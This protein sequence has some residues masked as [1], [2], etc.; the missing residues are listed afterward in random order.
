MK[1]KYLLI[2]LAN[3]FMRS[4]HAAVKAYDIEEKI[5]FGIHSTLQSIS[6]TFRD[7][8]A[9]HV[10]VM[11]E[12]HSWRRSFYSR[13]K[14]NRDIARDA[15]TDKEA[16]ES[17]LAFEALNDL[18]D[19]FR[20]H[21]NMTVLQHPEL[22]A[23]DLIAGWIQGHPDGEHVICSTDSDFYQLLAPNVTQYSGVLKELH[24]ISGIYD[25]KGKLVLEK[26]TGLPK[27]VPDP[28]F[29]LFEK[30]VRGDPGDYVFSA[31][32]GAS[33]KG[34]K[35]RVG[36]I[37]AFEDREKQGYNYNN[38]MLQRWTD[39]NG[40]EH[41]VLDDFTRN[42]ILIDLSAQPAR[43]R[44]EL[45]KCVKDGAVSKNLP[46]IGAHFLKLCGRHN[47]VKLS[48]QATTYGAI[49]SAAYKE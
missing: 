5:A 27:K 36:I 46:M 34:T 16:K 40:V 12:G 11:L 47:L 41:K 31:Y 21:T 3:T 6:S 4:L 28:K 18:I 44:A 9:T 42:T 20:N 23:D 2:D 15:L 33:L 45:D 8:H 22:E 26:K 19:F 7:Q 48:E 39:H 25:V 29:I 43:I 13:Y 17:K 1:Q 37:E 10:V 24:T 35:N 32:P 49:F 38:F 14:G 30:C